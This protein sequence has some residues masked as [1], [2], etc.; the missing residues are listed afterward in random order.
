[1]VKER[2]ITL[3]KTIIHKTFFFS[4]V[5]YIFHAF[6]DGTINRNRQPRIQ[7]HMVNKILKQNQCLFTK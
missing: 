2:F 4:M 1:M 6:H 7:I 3:C 5:K